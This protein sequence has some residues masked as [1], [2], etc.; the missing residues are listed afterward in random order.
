MSWGSCDYKTLARD[1]IGIFMIAIAHGGLILR[2]NDLM[3]GQVEVGEEHHCDTTGAMLKILKNR[4]TIDFPG[5]FLMWPMHK[6]AIVSI[7]NAEKAAEIAG[8]DASTVSAPAP[9][10]C[11]LARCRFHHFMPLKLPGR[12]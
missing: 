6:D 10:G 5:M 12:A 11:G 8:V 1:S 7:K 2:N 4:K 3:R 9:D